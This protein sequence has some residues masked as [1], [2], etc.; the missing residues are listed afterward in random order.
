MHD[1][2]STGATE[3]SC[4]RCGLVEAHALTIDFRWEDQGGWD[5][6]G[7]WRA[8]ENEYRVCSRCGY[9]EFVEFTGRIQ[10]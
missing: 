9:E 7:P 4:R 10:V 8:Q 5:S 2:V 3:H 6:I 1:F